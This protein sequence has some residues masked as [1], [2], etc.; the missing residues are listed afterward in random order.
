MPHLLNKECGFPRL[1]SHHSFNPTG[2]LIMRVNFYFLAFKHCFF[3]FFN[4]PL[5]TNRCK[6]TLICMADKNWK[7][8]I[9]IV[10]WWRMCGNFN[11]KES[12]P[13]SRVNYVYTS[14][15]VGFQFNN[16]CICEGEMGEPRFQVSQRSGNT[17]CNPIVSKGLCALN[18]CVYI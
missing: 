3:F 2:L 10:I 14:L 7:S 17:H 6:F 9:I 12:G 4:L 5:V 8:E 15:L 1:H 18:P 16:S 11:F 13:P